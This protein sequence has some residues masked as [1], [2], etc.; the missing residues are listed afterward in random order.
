[1]LLKT[2]RME[3]KTATH[4]VGIAVV[5]DERF[6]KLQEPLFQTHRAYARTHGYEYHVLEPSTWCRQALR[7]F[8]FQKHCTVRQFLSQQAPNY[9]LFVMD[10]DV[11]TAA[12][13]VTLDRWL[14][15]DTEVLLY[16][17]SWNFEIT[18]GNYMVRNTP[19]GKHFLHT[20]E[21]YDFKA[22]NITGFHSSDN[23]AIHLV[24][25]NVIESIPHEEYA[26]CERLYLNLTSDV[27]NLTE[28]YTFVA[29][30]RRVLGPNRHW[31]L[32][33][34]TGTLTIAHRYHGFAIDGYIVNRKPGGAIPF[35]HGESN[36]LKLLKVT[37]IQLHLTLQKS[38]H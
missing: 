36:H 16:E 35:Y 9:T 21:Q 6:Q 32:R 33:N 7:G 28:Y 31:Q 20:W 37:I 27:S 10:G 30:T 26:E 23:G 38:N 4:L 34:D 24:V 3:N 5:S 19:F 25:L 11:I 12:P 8:F 14:N 18:A 13:N 1:M 29:C 15:Q 17:R 22:R 2:A